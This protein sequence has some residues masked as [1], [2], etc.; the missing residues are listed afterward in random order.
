MEK[1]AWIVRLS[2][3]RT[4]AVCVQYKTRREPWCFPKPN[5]ILLVPQTY[6]VN[7]APVRFSHRIYLVRF[8][9]WKN[10]F[11]FRH[12]VYLG[13]LR[14]W[15]NLVK[16]NQ[17]DLRPEPNQID[18]L[19]KPNQTTTVWWMSGTTIDHSVVLC[20]KMCWKYLTQY[21][22]CSKNSR[23]KYQPTYHHRQNVV[24]KELT[25][26]WKPGDIS[27]MFLY[28]PETNKQKQIDS[29]P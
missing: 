25:Q 8:R 19:L 23:L 3:H 18:F 14:H 1:V 5:P 12:Y 10:L 22:M 21:L 28:T 29:R 7:L 16:P 17:V 11:R 15:N 24:W 13:R 27:V 4:S 26:N 2:K 9:Y 20:L 6:Q